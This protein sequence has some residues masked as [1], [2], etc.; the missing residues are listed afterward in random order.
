MEKFVAARKGEEKKSR[1]QAA[2]TITGQ[3]REEHPLQAAAGG[4][5]DERRLYDTAARRDEAKAHRLQAAGCRL[6][7]SRWRKGE[8]GWGIE[9]TGTWGF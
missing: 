3:D 2:A 7:P 6:L 4:R 9:W 8:A 5:G 1:P